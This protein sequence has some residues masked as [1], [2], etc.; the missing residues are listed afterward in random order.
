M[1][2]DPPS[3]PAEHMSFAAAIKRAEA[4]RQHIRSLTAQLDQA[5]RERDL[6]EQQVRSLTRELQAAR[7]ELAEL[8]SLAPH[9]KGN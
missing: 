2:V 9:P 6:A 1:S 3:Q 8:R 7:R 4:Q 5:H